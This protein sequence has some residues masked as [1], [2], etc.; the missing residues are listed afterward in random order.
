MDANGNSDAFH[1]FNERVT[2]TSGEEPLNVKNRV[3]IAVDA[4]KEGVVLGV[5]H[6]KKTNTLFMDINCIQSI[7]SLLGKETW[8]Q[9]C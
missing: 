7:M 4:D 5:V 3:G 8:L 6:A 1:S 9:L 2:G